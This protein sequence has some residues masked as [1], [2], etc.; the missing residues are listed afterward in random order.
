MNRATAFEATVTISTVLAFAAGAWL[1]SRGAARPAAKDRAW[2]HVALHPLTQLL[3]VCL[4][5]FVNQVLFGAYVLGAHGGSSRFVAQYISPGWFHVAKSGSLGALVRFVAAH[6]DVT[7]LSPSVLRVQAFLELP[8]TLFAYLA[9]A[10]LL[11][12]ETYRSLC[13]L[14]LLVLASISFSFTFSLV[15][16]SL[17]NPWTRDDLFLRALAAVTVPFYVAWLARREP[18]ADA[19]APSGPHGVLGLLSFLAGA[20]AIAWIVLAIYDAFLL[21]NL[22]HLPSYARGLAVALVVAAGASVA[23]SR[24]DRLAPGGAAPSPSMTAC[25]ASLRAFTILFF[26][27]SLSIRYWGLHPTAMLA[28]ASLVGVGLA[29]GGVAAVRRARTAGHVF[30]VCAAAAPALLAGGWAGVVAVTTAGH[31]PVPE[32]LLARGALSFLAVAIV[33]FRFVE[34]AL[35]WALPH[36]AKA[37]ADQT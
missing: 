21:Y 1:R 28:A 19:S 2:W 37:E 10:R 20:G 9:V 36:E 13:R 29:V 3:V 33:T 22:A 25:V 30:V 17:P 27:P 18:H 23:S 14:P 11:G 24:V 6:V 35:C 34:M 26:I 4:L 31:V 12:V 7:W 8:F 16:L 32:L 15:E 5:L